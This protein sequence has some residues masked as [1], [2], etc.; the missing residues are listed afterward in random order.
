MKENACD[1][2]RRIAT[3][4]DYQDENFNEKLTSVEMIEKMFDA[5][6]RHILEF[7]DDLDWEDEEDEEDDAFLPD[8]SSRISSYAALISFIFSVVILK[9]SFLCVFVLL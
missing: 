6:E 2:F 7:A 3:W 4:L 1:K 9:T 8:R 5:C